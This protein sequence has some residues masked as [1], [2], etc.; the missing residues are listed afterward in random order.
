MKHQRYAVTYNAASN[1]LT[2]ISEGYGFLNYP[3]DREKQMPRIYQALNDA[4]LIIGGQKVSFSPPG[5]GETSLKIKNLHPSV[6]EA[7][8]NLALQRQDSYLLPKNVV[9]MRRKDPSS[10]TNMDTD[11]GLAESLAKLYSLFTP[12]HATSIDLGPMLKKCQGM[13]E[14]TFYTA[15]VTFPDSESAHSAQQRYHM[16]VDVFGTQIVEL[17]SDVSHK[18]WFNSRVFNNLSKVIESIL[19]VKAH[20]CIVDKKEKENIVSLK[21]ISSRSYFQD[22]SPTKNALDQLL[23]GEA[24]YLDPA[25]CKALTAKGEKEQLRELENHFAGNLS[26]TTVSKFSRINVCGTPEARKEAIQHLLKKT[27]SAIKRCVSIKRG[28]LKE[29]LG[30]DG[31]GLQKLTDRFR[32]EF[33]LNI[34][35]HMLYF[36]ANDEAY[37]QV[38]KHVNG[39]SVGTKSSNSEAECI[40]TPILVVFSPNP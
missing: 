24:V 18:V 28:G 37:Q 5:Q 1:A 25:V 32:I 35:Q 13:K 22:I 2:G 21:L 38:L 8:I 26:I 6:H 19:A 40:G 39:L 36:Y 12:F 10:E 3:K 17:K 4:G 15:L 27:Q 33:D 31:K 14:Q 11:F 7:H 30:A 29:L 20:Y 23:K 34:R 16:Q 9:V